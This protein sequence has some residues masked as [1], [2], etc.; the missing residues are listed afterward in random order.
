MQRICFILYDYT[1][2]GGAERATSKLLRELLPDYTISLI[3]V[4]NSH[5]A[6]PYETIDGIKYYKIIQSKGSIPGNIIKITKEI[7][8]ILR[9]DKIDIAI[10]VDMATA[11]MAVMGTRHTGAKLI[12]CDRSSIFNETM[13]A[14]AAL[15][16]YTWTGVKFSD[17]IQVMTNEG[18]RGLIQKYKIE[19]SKV[20]VIPNWIDERAITDYSYSFN[21]KRIVSVGRAAP[22]K[23]YE[24]LLKVAEKIKPELKGWEWHIW[25]DFNSRYGRELMEE[26]KRRQLNDFVILKGTTNHIYDEYH[27]YS[28][29]VLTSKYEGMPNV[30]LEAQGSKL[31]TIAYNCKTGPSEL[32]EDG[33]NGFLI[34]LNDTAGMADAILK[35]AG[36][37]K[38]AGDLS[39]HSDMNYIRFSKASVI[40]LWK[41]LL[42]GLY[43]RSLQ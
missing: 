30:I 15:R 32:I 22:E 26:V 12:V 29:F 42:G 36:S 19:D 3:S 27:K 9:K 14:H 40:Q 2:T 28:F 25:G 7:R 24:E 41:E 17:A 35:L 38:L 33:V 5:T 11:F 31:P 6:D 16:F 4:F 37:E 18:K 20:S 21:Q 43:A 39:A 8:R 10:A 34:P 13:Y 23:N 1:Q